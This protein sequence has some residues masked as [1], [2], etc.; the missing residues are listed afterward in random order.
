MTISNAEL[1][2]NALPDEVDLVEVLRGD[3]PVGM[4]TNPEAIAPDLAVTFSGGQAGGPPTHYEGIPG[5]LEGWSDWLEPWDSYRIQF[6]EY[7][8]AGDKV[9][10]NATVRARSARDDVLIEHDPAAVWTLRDGKAV[11][12]TFFLDRDEARRFA[13]IA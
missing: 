6:E 7:L 4:F 1:L 3:D 8:A 5:L 13:G 2:K 11:A 12:V 9:L 10:I